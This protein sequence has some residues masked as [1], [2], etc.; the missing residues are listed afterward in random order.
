MLTAA[1]LAEHGYEVE[2]A[3]LRRRGALLEDARDNAIPIHILDRRFKVDPLALAKLRRLIARH[4][5]EIVHA[6]SVGGALHAAM[7]MARG[8]GPG[9]PRLVA[10]LFRIARWRSPLS[11]TV[12]ARL[13]GRVDRFVTSSESVR[14]WYLREGL[15]PEKFRIIASASEAVTWDTSG[16]WTGAHAANDTSRAALLAELGLPVDAKLIGVVGRL[17]P[18]KRV[19]DLIWA[20]DLL[21]VLH[22]NLRLL[23]IGDG[24]LRGELER[25]ARLASDLTHI[26]FLGERGDTARIMAHLDV[27]WN[28]SD[29]VAQSIAIVEAMGAG[30]PVIASDVPVNRELVVEGET[31]YLIPIGSRAGRAARA[32]WTDRIFNSSEL[33]QSLGRAARERFSRF[34]RREKMIESTLSLYRELENR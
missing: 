27:L 32:R 23:V 12:R 26:Q 13:G 34:H 2:V 11:R 7:A 16:E 17:V 15:A 29:N 9:E 22:D 1:G 19:R 21:R 4:Q 14:D 10:S 8:R 25:Y 33:A 6:W 5:P 24:P 18:E 20:A 30:V 3:A 31:G 28:G